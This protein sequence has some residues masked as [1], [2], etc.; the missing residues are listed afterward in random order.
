M[1]RATFLVSTAAPFGVSR[2]ST[3]AGV[4]CASRPSSATQYE[5]L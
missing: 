5:R 1:K 3:S 4:Q 2:A